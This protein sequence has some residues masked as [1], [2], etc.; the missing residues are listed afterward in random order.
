MGNLDF[1]NEIELCKQHKK[2]KNR[3]QK[4]MKTLGL[5]P[6]NQVKNALIKLL[7]TEEKKN[8]KK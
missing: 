2:E 7:E 8:T 1:I 6:T 3:K 5:T 4:Q